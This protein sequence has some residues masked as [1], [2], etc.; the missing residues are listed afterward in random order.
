MVL[1]RD[2]HTYSTLLTLL[3]SRIRYL[4]IYFDQSIH[5]NFSDHMISTVLRT[6][7]TLTPL[8][9]KS[10]NLTG[11][12][13]LGHSPY[14]RFHGSPRSMSPINPHICP[15]HIT[16][17]I[18]QQENHHTPILMRLT[19]STQHIPLRPQLFCVWVRH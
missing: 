12:W 16:T 4:R 2:Q 10:T 3:L 1:G 6:T 7:W 13:T 5:M 9:D 14:L 11:Q 8:S 19:Q 17:R 18:T 15:R